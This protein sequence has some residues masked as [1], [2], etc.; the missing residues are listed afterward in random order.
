M[1][2]SLLI[3]L[4]TTADVLRE[5]DLKSTPDYRWEER[6]DIENGKRQ[7]TECVRELTRPSEDAQ[8]APGLFF[9]R[10]VTSISTS[11]EEEEESKAG[12]GDYCSTVNTVNAIYMHILNI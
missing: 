5:K 10:K 7:Q 4:C 11:E 9:G 12:D 3:L 1:R 6:G 8:Q 2:Y